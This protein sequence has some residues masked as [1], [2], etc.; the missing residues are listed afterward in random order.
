MKDRFSRKTPEANAGYTIND[1][2]KDKELR[3]ITH[4]GENLGVVTREKALMLAK[5]V[6]LD[7]VMIGK[8]DFLQPVVKIMDFGKFLYERKKK[9]HE[10]KK[11]QKVVQIKE[12][13][14][15]PNIGDQDYQVKMKRAIKFLKD[16]KKVKFTLQFR[17][18]QM[19]MMNELGSNFFS[20]V[21]KDLQEASIGQ[22][23]EEKESRGRPFW[24]KIIYIK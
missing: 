7:L 8:G 3:L 22:I 23:V 17:G 5:D 11:H 1:K 14:M 15:R 19:I 2:I 18:R 24:S 21:S 9:Q 6:N 12:V 16:G 10:S 20:R 13:K 4:T